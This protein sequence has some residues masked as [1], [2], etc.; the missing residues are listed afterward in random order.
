MSDEDIL[1][2]AAAKG[3][4]D[5]TLAEKSKK[6]K[7]KQPKVTQCR[8]N[9]AGAEF[10]HHQTSSNI[11]AE[12]SVSKAVSN[13]Q[14]RSMNGTNRRVELKKSLHPLSDAAL[15]GVPKYTVPE[16]QTLARKARTERKRM[17]TKTV[18]IVFPSAVA[19]HTSHGKPQGN[20]PKTSS[21]HCCHTAKTAGGRM[22]PPPKVVK[23]AVPRA[24]GDRMF[25]L[26]K[27]VRPAVPSHPRP[28]M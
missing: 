7:K 2:R 28:W 9:I 5:G 11:K 1:A 16:R 20:S 6:K 8:R 21:Q 25:L 27:V 23:P 12:L 10:L 4:L 24:A 15:S 13:I 14:L 17:E 22:F 3:L 26:P 18:D 19:P